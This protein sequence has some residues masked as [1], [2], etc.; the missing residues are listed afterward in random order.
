MRSEG[1]KKLR[2]ALRHVQ[3]GR[4]CIERQLDVIAGL[5]ARGLPTEEAER[6]LTWLE[7]VQRA[8]ENHYNHALLDGQERA[9]QHEPLAAI[10]PPPVSSLAALFFPTVTRV[11]FFQRPRAT[12]KMT[13]VEPVAV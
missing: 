8:F 11:S 1:E 9:S 6:V 4:K 10:P 12:A 3:R 5:R 2:T 7:A 13:A